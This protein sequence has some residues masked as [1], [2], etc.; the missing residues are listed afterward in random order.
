[1]DIY[2]PGPEKSL[3]IGLHAP[4]PYQTHD[5]ILSWHKINPH[6]I[7]E[8]DE[9][10]IQINVNFGKFWKCGFYDY[11]IVALT[12]GGKIEPCE[13]VSTKKNN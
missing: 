6:N 7:E 12:P 5:P 11:R 9:N 1:M 8:I 3:Y 2:K 13:S 4:T 10:K